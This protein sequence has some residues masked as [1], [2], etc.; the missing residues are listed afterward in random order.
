MIGDQG[1]TWRDQLV[2]TGAA[3]APQGPVVGGVPMVGSNDDVLFENVV[4][5]WPLTWLLSVSL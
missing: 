1:F 2:S 5:G 3:P 4:K